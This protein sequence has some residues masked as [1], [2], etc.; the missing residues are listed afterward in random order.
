MGSIIH[1]IEGSLKP[2]SIKFSA[3]TVATG[4]PQSNRRQR[5]AKSGLGK[6]KKS[7]S[8][9]LR[10]KLE[11]YLHLD[12]PWVQSVALAAIV[13]NMTGD[14][15]LWVLLVNPPSTGKTELVQMFDLVGQ[16]AW[17]AEVTENTFLSGLTHS[18]TQNAK[19]DKTHSL[20]HR[21]TDS[22]ILK[23]KPPIRVMLIQ[24]LTGL[25]TQDRRKRD[26][27]FGQL[28]QIY[29]GRLVK[30]TGMGSDLKWEGYLG[31]FGAVTPI[32]DEVSEINTILGERIILYR[33]IRK[34][35]QAEAKK[36]VQRKQSNWRTEVAEEV[37][38][39]VAE[40]EQNISQVHIPP[41]AISRLLDLAH[42]TAIGRTAVPRDGYNKTL[43]SLP[44]PEG[45]ARLVRQFQ[46]LLLGLCAVRGRTSPTKKELNIC[47][48]VARDTIPQIRLRV[49][50]E[51][52]HQ[53]GTQTELA[54]HIGLPSTTVRYLVEDLQVLGITQHREDTWTLTD[55]FRTI[56]E[57]GEVFPRTSQTQSFQEKK[58]ESC[59]VN[60]H[61]ENT[62]PPYD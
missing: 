17:L 29:D 49:I 12:D 59:G 51:L 56:C 60:L 57:K 18:G 5:R 47:T 34:N 14:E 62:P 22:E 9:Q 42:F 13:A 23:G 21:W 27:V 26:A 31:L 6:G 24:D 55:S 46:K 61:H 33:P 35:A 41:W 1:L 39:L 10:E 11:H 25:I 32:I 4:N 45:P 44:E 40:A 30:S 48:K 37:K 58:D 2:M 52:F 54:G 7:P 16:C 53:A 3:P 19:R 38:R 15:P 20:L 36:A 43:K 28:R 8:T 50:E